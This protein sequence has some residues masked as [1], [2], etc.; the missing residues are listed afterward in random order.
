ML[1]EAGLQLGHAGLQRGDLLVE[2]KVFGLD[3]GEQGVHER[4]HGWGCG[5]P[6]EW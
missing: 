6:I 1:A 4:T 5:G 2:E 3:L